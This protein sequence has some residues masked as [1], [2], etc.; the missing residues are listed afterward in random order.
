M[1]LINQID[2]ILDIII[3]DEEG[4]KVVFKS[5]P[6]NKNR[7]RLSILQRNTVKFLQYYNTKQY[8]TNGSFPLEKW[9]I[10]TREESEPFRI[11]CNPFEYIPQPTFTSLPINTLPTHGPIKD[12]MRGV[13]KD[14]SNFRK[15]KDEKQWNDW[16][17]RT[18]V[19]ARS[20]FLDKIF[21]VNYKPKDILMI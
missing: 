15:L 17:N 20:Q 12:F 3:L 16:Y 6:K 21:D 4:L 1:L 9:L 7:I 14:A 18:K 11:S 8:R 19:Q 2:T 5:I 10:I 13:K